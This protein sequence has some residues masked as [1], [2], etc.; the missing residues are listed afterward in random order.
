LVFDKP[1]I[2][3][4]SVPGMAVEEAKDKQNRLLHLTE[5]ELHYVQQACS[6]FS[7]VQQ[8]LQHVV[9]MWATWNSTNRI[10]ND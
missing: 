10:K 7:A 9:C 2:N 8:L 1:Q 4:R 6:N 5:K 3:K